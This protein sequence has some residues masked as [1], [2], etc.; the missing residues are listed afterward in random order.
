MNR[1]I[2]CWM[3]DGG[4]M[5]GCKNGIIHISMM[6]KKKGETMLQVRCLVACPMGLGRVILVKRNHLK[7]CHVSEIT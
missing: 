1:K 5:T 7:P 3:V 4:C 6:R 2:C